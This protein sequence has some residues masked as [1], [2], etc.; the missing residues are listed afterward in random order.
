MRV[1]VDEDLAS[2]TLLRELG[3]IDGIEVLPPERETGDDDVWSRAQAR[4]AALLTMNA[5]DFVPRAR[6]QPEHAGLLLVSRLNEP[7][8]MSALQIVQAV[9]AIHEAYPD[10]VSH[11]TLSVNSFAVFDAPR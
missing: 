10:G 11:L 8:D 7:G 9:L 6:L 5:K 4:G 2:K 3:K 1:L